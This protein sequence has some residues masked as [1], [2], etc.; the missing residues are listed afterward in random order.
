M[1]NVKES[2]MEGGFRRF[3][4]LTDLFGRE[5]ERQRKKRGGREREREFFGEKPV[6]SRAVSKARLPKQSEQLFSSFL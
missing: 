4:P 5:G 1:G 3:E 2:G 6:E